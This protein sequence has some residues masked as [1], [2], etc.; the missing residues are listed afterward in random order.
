MELFFAQFQWFGLVT[1]LQLLGK[2]T[3]SPMMLHLI[4]HPPLQSLKE[5]W[6][7]NTRLP[8]M[9]IGRN[10]PGVVVCGDTLI[11]LLT[12]CH[13]VWNR[14]TNWK[15]WSRLVQGWHWVAQTFGDSYH[16]LLT[17]L[18][19]DWSVQLW[20]WLRYCRFKGSLILF[21][22]FVLLNGWFWPTFRILF[23]VNNWNLCIWSQW[24][25]FFISLFC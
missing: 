17:R 3:L 7:V 22:G 9:S 1:V 13:W 12:L 4:G 11:V 8:R 24:T 2:V 6:L 16:L 5:S 18:S 20:H 23:V 25:R 15:W 10:A 21:N 19:W 14:L